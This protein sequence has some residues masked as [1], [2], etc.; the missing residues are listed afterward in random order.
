MISHKPAIGLVGGIGS[1]KSLVARLLTDLGAAWVNAD[2]LAREAFATDEV[3]VAI[4]TMWGQDVF[5][6]DGQIDRAKVAQ[7]VFASRSDLRRLEM[8]IHPWIARRRTRLM[9]DLAQEPSVKAFVADAPLLFEA[10]LDL[11]CDCVVFVDCP[12]EV[13]LERLWTNRGW[14]PDELARRESRQLPLDFKRDRAD[15]IVSNNSDVDTLVQRVKHVFSVIC[16]V[17]V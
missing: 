1:G 3:K 10:N 13:R 5:L 2:D 7:R 11:E 12:R 6:P 15:Y 8:V 9:V 17:C 16:R 14:R 4:R